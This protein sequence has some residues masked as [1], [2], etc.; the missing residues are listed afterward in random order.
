MKNKHKMTFM[1]P[2]GFEPVSYVCRGVE[3]RGQQ[4]TFG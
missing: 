2:P 4:M 1:T 3:Q